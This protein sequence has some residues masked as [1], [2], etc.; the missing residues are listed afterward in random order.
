MNKAILMGRLTKDPEL[1]TTGS[2]I[3]VCTFTLAVDRRFKSQTGE[4][5]TDFIP[6]VVW[7]QTAEF[8]NRYFRQGSKMVVVGSIQVR[9][10]DDN[11]GNRRWTTEVIGD[12]VYF[13][14]SKSADE[15]R[16]SSGNYNNNNYGNE[17]SYGGGQSN[18]SPSTGS[19]QRSSTPSSSQ[20]GSNA[21]EQ[22]SGFFEAP[23]DDIGL[24]FDL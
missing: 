24:P 5:Q 11:E 14:E 1:K 23:D 8:V 17:P 20:G 12:E 10:W 3:S 18:G 15:S 16:R 2:N 22:N 4:R 6:I 7:R 13:A 21:N 9:S 19:P